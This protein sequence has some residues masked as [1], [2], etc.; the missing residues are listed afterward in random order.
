[1]GI[2]MQPQNRGAMQYRLNAP[3]SALLDR[4]GWKL[5]SVKLPS[6]AVL[7]ESFTHSTT[8]LGLIG[9]TWEGRHYSVAL[10]DLLY[11]AERLKSAEGK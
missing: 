4:P 11:K 2:K 9:V 5:E 6:G 1:M 3:I 7:Q 8:L 10:T